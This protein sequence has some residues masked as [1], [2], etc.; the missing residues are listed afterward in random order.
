[1]DRAL[2][3]LAALAALALTASGAEAGS[4]TLHGFAAGHSV[5]DSGPNSW[6]LGNFGRTSNAADGDFEVQA[7]LDW[8]PG[9]RWLAHAQG[10]ARRENPHGGG[11]RVGLSDAY[12]QFRP[13]FSSRA[14]L[15]FRAGLFFP[16]TSLEN[17]GRAWSSPY[18]M[19]LSSLNTWIAEEIRLTGVEGALLLGGNGKSELQLAG[20]IFGGNDTQGALI[21]WRGWTYGRRLTVLGEVLPLPPLPTLAAGGPFSEQ[22]PD[23]TKPIGELDGR[24]GR[25]AR[26]RWA[27]PN[28]FKLQVAHTDSRGDRELH[29]GQYSWD[30]RFTQFGAELPLWH[31]AALIGELARGDTAMGDPR[32][33]HV[34][35]RFSSRYLMWTW[36][37]KK[38]RI[39]AR[40]DSFRNQDRDGTAEP[41]QE[42]GY[43]WTAALFW[44]PHDWSRFGV[45]VL[46]VHAQRPAAAFSGFDPDT[47][48]RAFTMEFRFYF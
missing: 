23:G 44:L 29:H 13:E 2:G 12:L 34:D 24:R 4:I 25:Q 9:L 36:G 30:T 40:Y 42:N 17:V 8:E 16:P 18:T 35:V 5:E 33:A 14:A 6:L 22:R 47:D 15:R 28:G 41:D 7:A 32:A 10:L 19:T 31:G 11:K 1:M 27:R 39:S 26:A 43:S 38:A 45:E 20:A 37:G 48:T 3:R 46:D 21:A